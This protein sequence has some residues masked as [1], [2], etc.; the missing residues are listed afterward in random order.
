MLRFVHLTFSSQSRI[1]IITFCRGPVR[2]RKGQSLSLSLS[3]IHLFSCS[4]YMY[5]VWLPPSRVSRSFLELQLSSSTSFSYCVFL[6]TS[7]SFVILP[8]TC[9]HSRHTPP[10]KHTRDRRLESGKFLMGYYGVPC[11]PTGIHS[12]ATRGHNRFLH[13]GNWF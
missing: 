2:G 10:C 8:W 3:L 6:S 11:I 7:L 13:L 1:S 12:G 5:I 9:A 4:R